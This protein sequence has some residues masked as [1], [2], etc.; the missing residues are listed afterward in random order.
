MI[1]ESLNVDTSEMEYAEKLLFCRALIGEILLL[2]ERAKQTQVTFVDGLET[3]VVPPKQQADLAFYLSQYK[4]KLRAVVE[5][6]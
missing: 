6:L 1:G 4:V 3:L 2:T 5:R